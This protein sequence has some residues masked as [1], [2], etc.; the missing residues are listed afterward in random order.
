MVAKLIQLR[1]FKK[2]ELVLDAE[3]TKKVLIFFFPF[4]QEKIQNLSI[5]DEHREFAQALLVEAIDAS[6]AMGWVHLTFAFVTNQLRKPTQPIKKA[7]QKLA[8]SAAKYWFKHAKNESLMNADIYETV[9]ATISQNFSRE[10]RKFFDPD[11][12]VNNSSKYAYAAYIDYGYK[13]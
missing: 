1:Q 9:R 10:M 4:F 11:Y 13:A 5:N 8:K 6:Y 2:E 3:E 12:A 7:I